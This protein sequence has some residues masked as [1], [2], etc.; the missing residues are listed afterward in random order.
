MQDIVVRSISV[1]YQ[2][3]QF[4]HY[5][6]IMYTMQVTKVVSMAAKIIQSQLF[7]YESSIPVQ[8]ESLDLACWGNII[9]TKYLRHSQVTKMIAMATEMDQSQLF[10]YKSE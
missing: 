7:A 8:Y 2:R 3:W 10:A 1:Q 5:D 9:Y 6:N 4:S